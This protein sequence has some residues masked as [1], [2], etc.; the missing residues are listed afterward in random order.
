MPTLP[1]NI[2][3]VAG[4]IGILI[5][6]FVVLEFNRR[7]EELN[8]L[9]QQNELVREQATQAVQTQVSLQTQVAFAGSTAAVEQWARTEGKY[10]QD[11]DL[12]VVPVAQPGSAPLELSTPVPLPTPQPN[13]QV[14]WDLFFGDH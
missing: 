10:I 8:V 4:I 7:L 6:A 3:R 13:W 9:N 11:G 1:I 14:W 2:R 5:L 12:P